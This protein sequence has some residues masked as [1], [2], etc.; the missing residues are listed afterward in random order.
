[1]YKAMDGK[2][3]IGFVYKNNK[4]YSWAYIDKNTK[5]VSVFKTHHTIEHVK[6]HLQWAYNCENIRFKRMPGL[7]AVDSSPQI[8]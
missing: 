5:R 1:M 4:S 8:G 3:A 2:K 7:Y 6:L